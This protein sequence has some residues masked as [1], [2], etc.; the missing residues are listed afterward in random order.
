MGNFCFI[1]PPE[2][3]NKKDGEISLHFSLKYIED[4]KENIK[5]WR[6]QLQKKVG[7]ELKLK[8]NIAHWQKVIGIHQKSIDKAKKKIKK[9]NELNTK[10][11][12]KKSKQSIL[13]RKELFNINEVENWRDFKERLKIIYYY[14]K[15]FTETLQKSNTYNKLV[16]QYYD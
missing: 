2:Y 10:N 9:W 6:E 7:N 3:L 13:Q 12:G 4:I 11:N 14:K 1:I 15:P 16:N 8:N 5:S